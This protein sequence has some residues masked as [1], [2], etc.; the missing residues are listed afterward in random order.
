MPIDEFAPPPVPPSPPI[1]VYD[2]SSP[3]KVRHSCRVIMDEHGLN[4][5]QKDL[6]SAVIQ[7]ESGFDTKAIN[8]FSKDY[9]VCQ[10]NEFYWIGPGKY[11]ASIDEVLNFP[12]KSVR[13]MVEQYR[14]GHI[15]Y[16]TAFVNGSYKRF[17]LG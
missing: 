13:F 11:F 5:G 6:L 7:A 8:K 2:W 17:L 9:G 16:W 12:E 1:A 4:W 10:I 15:G 14:A 3:E